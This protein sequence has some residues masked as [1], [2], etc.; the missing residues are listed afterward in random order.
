M[1]KTKWAEISKYKNSELADN[2]R[3]NSLDSLANSSNPS[4]SLSDDSHD[5]DSGTDTKSKNSF[6]VKCE[7]Y[8]QNA[9]GSIR[10]W[11]KSDGSNSDTYDYVNDGNGVEKRQDVVG[12]RMETIPEEAEP[13]VSVKEILAR[14]ENLKDNKDGKDCNNNHPKVHTSNVVV[15]S[16]SSSSSSGNNN[17]SNN[18]N[19]SSASK[20]KDSGCSSSTSTSA[21]HAN[22]E[23]RDFDFWR[24]TI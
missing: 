9:C 17:C 12:S 13:K 1:N 19:S 8:S 5:S 10:S 16:S 22:K 7:V 4:E 21:K 20:I 23:V 3:A 24:G 2:F 18:S 14:F 6:T 11:T 15:S